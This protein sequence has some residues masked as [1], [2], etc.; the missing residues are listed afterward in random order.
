M[1]LTIRPPW[2]SA[3]AHI[4]ARIERDGLGADDQMQADVETFANLLGAGTPLSTLYNL[5]CSARGPN[6]D[7]DLRHAA[8]C[9]LIV[10]P[11]R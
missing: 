2:N 5:S 4:E 3:P 1:P 9:V 6:G 8:A 10:L 7:R 11:G